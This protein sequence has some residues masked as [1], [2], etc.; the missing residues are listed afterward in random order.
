MGTRSTITFCERRNENVYPIVNIY[1]QY[2]GYLEG[3]GKDLCEWLINKTIV[4][5]LPISN[6]NDMDIANGFGC[7]IAQ[8]IA[9]N[10][11]CVG[12]LYIIPIGD[13]LKYCDYNYTVIF[14]T[15]TET[16]YKASDRTTICV[17]NWGDSHFFEGSPEELLEYIKRQSEVDE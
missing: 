12:D 9:N 5:G 4:N 17:D 3:V 2:D 7:L 16:P 14:D 8:Y 6:E 13:M 1:Q 15:N 11:M 10:K